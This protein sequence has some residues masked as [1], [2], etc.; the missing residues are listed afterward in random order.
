MSSSSTFAGRFI[1]LGAGGGGMS[2]V[3]EERF[4]SAWEDCEDSIVEVYV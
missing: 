2:A 1:R 3:S 4:I